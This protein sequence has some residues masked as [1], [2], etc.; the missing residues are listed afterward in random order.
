MITKNRGPY[1]KD[2]NPKYDVVKNKLKIQL[3]ID[4]DVRQLTFTLLLDM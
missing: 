1:L 3:D 2:D 4:F